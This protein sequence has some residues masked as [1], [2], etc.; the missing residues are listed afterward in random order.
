[1]MATTLTLAALT[2]SVISFG[3]TPSSCA[4][5][6]ALNAVWAL[7]PNSSRVVAMVRARVIVAVAMEGDVVEGGGREDEG[8]SED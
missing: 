3:E 8:G 1:M 5:R 2:C 4:A 7:P 6:L